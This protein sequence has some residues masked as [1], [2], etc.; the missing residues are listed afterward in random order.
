MDTKK[1]VAA[2]QDAIDQQIHLVEDLE[3]DARA[4]MIFQLALDGAVAAGASNEVGME[5][6]YDLAYAG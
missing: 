6:A 4:R 3:W 5:I 2:A 1:W